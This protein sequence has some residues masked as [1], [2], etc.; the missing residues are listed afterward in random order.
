MFQQLV[1]D[2]E[3]RPICTIEST[4]TGH[5]LQGSQMSDGMPPIWCLLFLSSPCY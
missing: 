3:S 1:A 4:K 2:L 5:D